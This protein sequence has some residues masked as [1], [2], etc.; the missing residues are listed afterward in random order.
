M[1]E[2]M[3]RTTKLTNSNAAL[4]SDILNGL[5]SLATPGMCYVGSRQK[6]GKFAL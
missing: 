2:E 3:P 1:W 4:M 5:C 6:D